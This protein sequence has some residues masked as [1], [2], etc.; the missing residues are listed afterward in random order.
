MGFR[1]L[2]EYTNPDLLL[3]DLSVHERDITGVLPFLLR[4]SSLPRYTNLGLRLFNSGALLS[5]ATPNLLV[6]LLLR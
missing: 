5:K 1:A 6:H 2:S 4:I 3:P